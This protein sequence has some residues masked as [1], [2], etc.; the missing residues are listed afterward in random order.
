VVAPGNSEEAVGGFGMSPDI[1]NTLL[2]CLFAFTVFYITLMYHRIKLE[3]LKR[4][5][6]TLKQEILYQ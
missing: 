5:V 1:R 2:F 6:D 3:Q 4:R